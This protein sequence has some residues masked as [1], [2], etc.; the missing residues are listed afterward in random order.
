MVTRKIHMAGTPQ[1]AD[2]EKVSLSYRQ[3]LEHKIF[4]LTATVDEVLDWYYSRDPV[5]EDFISDAIEDFTSRGRGSNKNILAEKMA[6]DTLLVECAA[7][8]LMAD[9][10]ELGKFE[11]SVLSLLP[12]NHLGSID[13]AKQIFEQRH[14]LGSKF[15]IAFIAADC[16]QSASSSF[17]MLENTFGF[18]AKK[19]KAWRRVKNYMQK[20]Q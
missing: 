2:Y 20:T 1:H 7:L 17:A 13:Y 12:H 5:G 11:K 18:P 8:I 19:P 15:D 14:L 6:T 4:S 3:D 16:F 10:L 9:A